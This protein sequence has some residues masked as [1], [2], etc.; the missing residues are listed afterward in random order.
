M[1]TVTPVDPSQS[2]RCD[3]TPDEKGRDSQTLNAYTS[4]CNG[5]GWPPASTST[6]RRLLD[7]PLLPKQ[8]SVDSLRSRYCR[9]ESGKHRGKGRP[10]QSPAQDRDYREKVP[11]AVARQDRPAPSRGPAGPAQRPKGSPPGPS[12]PYLALPSGAESFGSV[13]ELP[14]APCEFPCRLP[15]SSVADRQPNKTRVG[16]PDLRGQRTDR[17]ARLSTAVARRSTGEGP[18]RAT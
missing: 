13:V 1:S 2:V 7:T 17:S 9:C 6:T 3:S 11:A 12:Q 4:G 5:A 8:L 14:L 15:S 16:A 18:H 10:D